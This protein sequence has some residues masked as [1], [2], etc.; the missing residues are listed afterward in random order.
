[1]EG[2]DFAGGSFPNFAAGFVAGS[3]EPAS[4]FGFENGIEEGC[5]VLSLYLRGEDGEVAA[6]FLGGV[7]G[8]GVAIFSFEEEVAGAFILEGGSGEDGRLFG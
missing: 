4:F 6:S 8:L 2:E 1:V 7:G 3:S 5:E